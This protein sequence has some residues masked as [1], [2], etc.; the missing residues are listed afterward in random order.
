M[1]TDLQMTVLISAPKQKNWTKNFFTDANVTCYLFCRSGSRI[2]FYYCSKRYC[3]RSIDLRMC[4]RSVNAQSVCNSCFTKKNLLITVHQITAACNKQSWNERSVSFSV[5]Y[6]NFYCF[7]QTEIYQKKALWGLK[8]PL[9]QMVVSANTND[10]HKQ[11]K[12]S[13]SNSGIKNNSSQ[14]ENARI[15][16]PNRDKH[17]CRNAFRYFF[18][19]LLLLCFYIFVGEESRN[20]IVASSIYSVHCCMYNIMP[21]ALR[22]RMVT[23]FQ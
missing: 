21:Y 7:V 3:A 17:N 15:H 9:G 23:A 12:S 8:L 20:E 14:C 22:T 4:T 11:L 5:A 19:L 1:V 16:S 10:E 18:F 13:L 6:T 2:S